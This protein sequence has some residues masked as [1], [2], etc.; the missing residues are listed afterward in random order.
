[1]APG[2]SVR[3]RRVHSNGVGHSHWRVPRHHA[4]GGVPLGH[5]TLASVIDGYFPEEGVQL[6]LTRS[7]LSASRA[8]LAPG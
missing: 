4:L 7:N 3:S 8:Q 2:I 1:V 5:G 6:L